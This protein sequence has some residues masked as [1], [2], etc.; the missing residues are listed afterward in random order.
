MIAMQNIIDSDKSL[1]T[2]IFDRSVMNHLKCK[3]DDYLVIMQS[4]Y[5]Y[6]YF[7]IAKADSGYRIRRYPKLR[8]IY[9]VNVS[10]KFDHLPEFDFKECTYFKKKNNTIRVILHCL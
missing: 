7:L 4:N 1:L 2:I 5:N 6:G 8:K 3:C 9:Q 10:F